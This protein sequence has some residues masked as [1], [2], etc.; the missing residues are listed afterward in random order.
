MPIST[1]PFCWLHA[2]IWHQK[3]LW[4]QP[5]VYF[6]VSITQS[7]YHCRK[8]LHSD[9]QCPS[10]AVLSSK[11]A[12]VPRKLSQFWSA[13]S[14]TVC[15]GII[16]CYLTPKDGFYSRCFFQ[17]NIWLCFHLKKTSTISCVVS[18]SLVLS[19]WEDNIIA[20]FHFF[21]SG[22]TELPHSQLF[23]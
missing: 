10:T 14:L 8:S 4:H 17:F 19:T 23:P 11:S 2:P 5:P 15:N 7:E 21:P 16:S 22:K 13:S 20:I 3:L 9:Y 12:I 18:K 6:P 1:I